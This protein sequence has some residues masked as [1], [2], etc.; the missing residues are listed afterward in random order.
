[1]KPFL[2]DSLTIG[3]FCVQDLENY[4]LDLRRQ[5]QEATN[6]R[7]T[8]MKVQRQN[9]ADM[10]QLTE[11]K[12]AADQQSKSLREELTLRMNQLKVSI[13]SVSL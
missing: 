3:A 13:S 5:L 2:G 1:M 8:L 11:Q 12:E 4:M 7:A 6:E 9:R 10:D